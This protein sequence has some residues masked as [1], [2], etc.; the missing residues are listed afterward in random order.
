ME[1]VEDDH[2][3]ACC[4]C[5]TQIA[6]NPANTCIN[7]LKSK[8]DITEGIPKQAVLLFC[9][10]CERYQRPPWVAADLESKELLA[11]C[12]KK[13]N[14]K[15]VKLQDASFQWTEPHSRRIKVRLVIQKE[16]FSG[17]ILQQTFIVEFVVTP[18]QCPE[19]A[20]SFTEHTW[21]ACLQVR[22]KV[23]HKRTFLYLEQMLLKY[24]ICLN[25]IGMKEMPMGLDFF[26][27]TKGDSNK[28][29]EF[30]RTVVPLTTKQSKRLI[31]QDD[32]NNTH[33][34]KFSFYAEIAPICKDDFV[35][36]P[37]KT[38]AGLGGVCPF[39]LCLRVTNVMHFVDPRTCKLIDLNGVAYFREPFTAAM[40]SAQLVEF[41]VLDVELPDSYRGGKDLKSQGEY[42][43]ASK[44]SKK[45]Q[46]AEVEVARASDFGVNDKT[47][48]ILT[49]LGHLLKPGDSVLGYETSA[50]NFH[51]TKTKYEIP[52]IVL[53]R[54]MFLSKRRAKKRNWKLKSLA[55]EASSERNTKKA[56]LT[57][58]ELEY[59]RF[60]EDL[61]EDEDMRSKVNLYRK[62]QNE[63]AVHGQE[64][65]M[66]D[67]DEEIPV[68]PEE[69]L[70][71]DV[72]DGMAK[73][74]SSVGP[75]T[76]T[77]VDGQN[78]DGELE[79]L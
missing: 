2:T 79:D 58:A 48:R 10:N 6:P 72:I 63:I 4:V 61:E 23:K 11:I 13:I 29:L 39:L 26:W 75:G 46:L 20:A 70:L 67:E 40:T 74:G 8:I 65:E 1:D 34:Y 52:E 71:D 12:L 57:K 53:V 5:G 68:V 62:Q 27:P 45:I 37:L 21:T 69:E 47:F 56:E 64:S 43:K 18:T 78:D 36:L 51:S 38:A 73:L 25:A 28:M 35:A 30:L 60:L 7:C 55:L 77:G 17:L 42:N 16:V 50:G 49:H 31:S 14:F 41:A 59:E 54:K 22:Q 15:T 9:R 66:D 3:I 33:K 32:H 76:Q 44:M 24:N 19:C